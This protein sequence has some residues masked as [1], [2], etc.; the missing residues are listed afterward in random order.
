MSALGIV[1]TYASLEHTLYAGHVVPECTATQERIRM[2]QTL[3]GNAALETSTVLMIEVRFGAA[4]PKYKSQ[5][6]LRCW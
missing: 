1:D 6:H 5:P 4:F 3:M 2:L